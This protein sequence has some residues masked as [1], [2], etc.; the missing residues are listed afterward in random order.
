MTEGY[1]PPE[2][3]KYDETPKSQ[4]LANPGIISS[5]SLISNR[6]ILP[7]EELNMALRAENLTP[8]G[9]AIKDAMTGSDVIDLGSG[10]PNVSTLVPNMAEVFSAKS[11]TGVDISSLGK[12]ADSAPIPG[13]LNPEFTKKY[14]E[15]DMLRFVQNMEPTNPVVIHMAGLEKRGT[16][17]IQSYTTDLSDAI[18]DKTRAGDSV[19][20]S[21]SEG[22]LEPNTSHFDLVAT[23]PY[24]D[25]YGT[26]HD[27]F[28]KVYKRK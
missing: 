27:N 1:T 11:Y 8:A 25:K 15:E 12:Y 19:I 2:I 7:P 21:T 10:N 22:S 13:K 17:E 23:A 18:T 20:I 28:L 26:K 3:F 5:E 24:V 9:R 14:V 16:G 6:V 4:L